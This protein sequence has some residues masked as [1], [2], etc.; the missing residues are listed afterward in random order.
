MEDGGVPVDNMSDEG[1]E[2]KASDL[3]GEDLVIDAK[4]TLGKSFETVDSSVRAILVKMDGG[5]GAVR[6]F[7]SGNTVRNVVT[8][9]GAGFV[10]VVVGV[11]EE[12]MLFGNPSVR[13][14]RSRS[15]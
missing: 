13:Y 15:T 14:F 1:F 10:I 5:G 11:G 8:G 7:G 9:Q 6:V 4:E 2:K 3:S 12:C